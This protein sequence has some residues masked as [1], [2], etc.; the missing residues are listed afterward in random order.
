VLGFTNSS[1]A[2]F[3][4]IT[5]TYNSLTGVLSLN[6]A[7]GTAT[8][9]QWQNA[10]DAVTYKDTAVVPL[11]NTRTISF[12]L[13]SDGSAQSSNTV[14]KTVTVT[15]TDQTPKVTGSGSTASY[16]SGAAP[17]TVDTH[18]GVSDADN[19]TQSSGTVS[20]SAGFH[21]GDTLSFTNSSNATFGNIIG[22]YDGAGTLTLTSA[23][24]TATDAQWAAAFSAVAFSSNSH[25]YGNRT[26]SFSV[27]D[28]TKTSVAASDTINVVNPVQVTTDSGSTSFVAGDNTASNPVSV[29]PGVTL[30]DVA[31]TT[32]STAT[33]S[34]TGNFH[35]G[36]D[37]LGF[38]NTSST[39]FGDIS[40]IYT[41]G[42]GHDRAMA[43]R[44]ARG[45]LCGFS[46]HAEQRDAHRQLLGDRQQRQCQQYGNPRG[47]GDGR[48]PDADHRDQRQ[49]PD[50]RRRSRGNGHRRQH[51][52]E[53]PG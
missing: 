19:T 46:H 53:R 6:S 51:C 20:V 1:P 34:I 31:T 24:A 8:I 36:E 26:L 10:F 15:A 17:T 23:G 30:A 49:Q 38:T 43:G 42:S 3:G 4:D 29:D 27:S 41:A 11:T 48:R 12:S 45:E 14:Q 52:R 7:S 16:G 13:T 47:D 39:T 35:A 37:V 33:V 40:A 9:A 22:T 28:G 21:T 2:Q 5:G 32:A 25:T 44:T 50:L 18:I